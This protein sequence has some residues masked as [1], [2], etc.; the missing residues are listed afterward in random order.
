MEQIYLKENFIEVNF[1]ESITVRFG[2]NSFQEL[3]DLLY[4]RLPLLTDIYLNKNL[5]Q[6]IPQDFGS[7]KFLSVLNLSKERA[8][9]ISFIFTTIA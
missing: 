9:M 7:L 4:Q 5:L 8:A 2:C 1:L 3:P 6:N